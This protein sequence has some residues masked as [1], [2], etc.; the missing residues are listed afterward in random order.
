L[1]DS[2]PPGQ[3]TK[4]TRRSSRIARRLPIAVTGIDALGQSYKENTSTVTI[5]RHGCDYL[6]RHFTPK[7]SVVM[8][9]MRDAGSRPPVPGC[10]V[11]VR[12][13]HTVRELFHVG[14]E[15]ETPGNVWGIQFP[16]EDWSS[17]PNASKG[18]RKAQG[19]SATDVNSADDGKETMEKPEEIIV[20]VDSDL[21]FGGRTS[22]TSSR[23]LSRSRIPRVAVKPPTKGRKW[24]IFICHASEDKDGFVRPLAEALRG[25]GLRVWYDEFTLLVGDSLRRSIDKGLARSRFGAVILSA[26]FFA[27]EWPQRELDGLVAKEVDG[28]RVILPV[29]HNVTVKDV[30]K[31]SPPLADRVATNSREGI[32]NVAAKLLRAINERK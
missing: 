29:W 12:R 32:R 18:E 15:F 26:A 16:P 11:W 4:Q 17:P 2:I 6:S 31:Y 27:K 5:N 8:L 19:I 30:R 21:S 7:N 28:R 10:V 14:I 24:D 25:E 1:R 22:S 23:R 20:N 9:E 13:P 3:T